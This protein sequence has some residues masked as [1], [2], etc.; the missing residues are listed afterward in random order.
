[1]PINPDGTFSSDA[2][3]YA[4]SAMVWQMLLPAGGYALLA[5]LFLGLLYTGFSPSFSP[6]FSASD[7]L[8]ARIS[9]AL[10]PFPVGLALFA[11]GY[12]RKV[13][14]LHRLTITVPRVFVLQLD[15]ALIGSV[16]AALLLYLLAP[17]TSYAAARSKAIESIYFVT[18]R[19]PISGNYG[20]SSEP[21]QPEGVSYGFA[22]VPIVWRPGDA[23]YGST[24]SFEWEKNGPLP[25]RLSSLNE[26]AFFADLLADVNKT[27]TGEGFVFVHGFHN[28]FNEAVLTTGK[29]AYDL[30]FRNGGDLQG[31][32]I[33][34][35]WPSGDEASS[36]DH[37][38]ES[39]SWSVKHFEEFIEKLTSPDVRIG[40]LHLIAHSMGTRVAGEALA[41]LPSASRGTPL[42]DNVVLAAADV[43]EPLFG[44][45]SP[46]ICRAASRVTLYVSSWDGA[47]MLS[48]GLHK[49][50]RVGLLPVHREG[51]D[52]VDTLGLDT[53]LRNLKHSYL[54]D[55]QPVLTDMYY[56]IRKDFPPQERSGLEPTHDG[57]CWQFEHR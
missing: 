57:C 38:Y 40:R 37:D 8:R 30:K 56:L 33:L 16:G 39:A 27:P 4:N 20:F 17:F 26:S 35:S 18:D 11:S 29:L 24:P 52:V 10:A 47:L 42:F 45:I 1:M 31:I 19:Q 23:G 53:S 28:P 5:V 41:R 14:Q 46:S 34:Y 48:S 54:F 32:A 2:S 3:D 15:W 50:T 21:S 13:L 12:S 55:S 43:N 22:Q 51:M 9:F 49:G 44:Q 7:L 6:T 36:Y 25:I